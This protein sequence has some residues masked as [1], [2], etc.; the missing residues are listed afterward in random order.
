MQLQHSYGAGVANPVGLLFGLC[1]GFIGISKL[2][3]RPVRSK[4]PII[5][6]YIVIYIPALWFFSLMV[7]CQNGDCI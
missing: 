2:E 4:V 6:F 1:V 3:M 5:I 7:G